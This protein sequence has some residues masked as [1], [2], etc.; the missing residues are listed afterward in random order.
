MIDRHWLVTG[1]LGF[2]GSAFVRL[3][4]R[5]RA[6]VR[7]TVL[8]AMTYAGDPRTTRGTGSSRA[9]SLTARPSTRRSA[10]APTRS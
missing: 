6:D 10:A 9:I 2:I 3:A 4:L 8:D 1:G 7:I 5:E